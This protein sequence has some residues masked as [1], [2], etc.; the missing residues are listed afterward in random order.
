DSATHGA[1]AYDP[2]VA[3][4]HHTPAPTDHQTSSATP[5]SPQHRAEP[6]HHADRGAQETPNDN[7]TSIENWMA[8]LRSSRR[9]IADS[10]EGRHHSG[11]GRSV[12]VNELLRRRDE[13]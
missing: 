10:D 9:R 1:S 8:E 4:G 6:A 3:A 2:A 5:G 7:R 12:S 13:D 11:D